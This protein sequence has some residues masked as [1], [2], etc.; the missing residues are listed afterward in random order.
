MMDN[1]FEICHVT[2]T[3][4]VIL[5]DQKVTMEVIKLLLVSSL[6]CDFVFFLFLEIEN[7]FKK[8]L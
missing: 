3:N 2:Y 6:K 4:S 5:K 1:L 8:V 7:L